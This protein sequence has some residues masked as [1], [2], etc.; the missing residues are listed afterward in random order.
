MKQE[1]IEKYSQIIYN[2]SGKES[3]ESE[4]ISNN[5]VSDYYS[6][7]AF[8]YKKF[9]SK[10]GALHLPISFSDKDSHASKLLYQA[11]SI[12]DL[13]NANGFTKV[14]EL[15]CGMGFN[16]N[17]LASKN[18]EVSFTGIDLTLNNIKEASKNAKELNNVNYKQMDFDALNELEEQYD[19]VFAVETLCHSK[20]VA[21]VIA[22]I[23]EKLSSNGKI[24]IYDGYVRPDAIPL[25]NSWDIQAY[26]LLSW[27]FA[28]NE[29]QDL[30]T[31]QSSQ[32]IQHLNFEEIKDYSVNVLPNYQ[33]FQRGAIK[34]FRYPRLL[35]FML[36]TRIISL[37][38]IKQMS[39]GLFGP[40]L[41]KKEYLGYYKIVL[42]KKIDLN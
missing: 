11:N 32:K 21:Q 41:I 7:S 16:S 15:G 19:L 31:L 36:K 22:N 34:A 37:A 4:V 13:I 24:I 8:F 14:L 23:S 17:Y 29:F 20:D 30:G 25:S 2:L 40:Y 9:H 10:E 26:Q 27:G 1:E 28:M 6:K 42:C 35:K 38:L 18:P 33:A 3:I 39:A 12:H 5:I